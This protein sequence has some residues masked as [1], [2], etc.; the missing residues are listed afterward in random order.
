MNWTKVI[1][2]LLTVAAITAC[3]PQAKV[4]TSDFE[5][6]VEDYIRKFPYQDTHNYVLMYTQGDPASFNTWVLGSEPTLVKA[7]DD[8]IV[9][10][11]NDTFY[12]M[13]FVI[14][15]NGPVVLGSSAPS[16]GRFISF[17]LMDDRNVNYRNVIFPKGTYTLYHGE[18]PEE[19]QGEAI[20]V[21]SN[22]SVVIV[23][24]EVKDKNNPEDLAAATAV[25]KGITI[26]G[27]E[28]EETP[29]LDLLSG[30]D[31]AVEEEALL[32]MEE[33]L[34]TVPFIETVVGPGKKPGTD[35]PYLYHAAGT[36]GGWGGPDPTHSTYESLFTDDAGETLNGANG[37]Y[38]ITTEEPP[39]DAFWSITVYDT[40]R[41]GFLHPNK[42]DRYHIN[43]TGAVKNADGTVTFTFKQKCEEGDLN[44]LEVPAGPFD[45]VIRYYLPSEKIIS[46]EW[47]L[48]RPKLQGE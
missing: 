4:Q 27:P 21:P 26:D 42:D 44:C 17:Q 13:A 18:K 15:E 37:T 5:K 1:T 7:G 36:K 25:F 43:N 39:V 3:S 22:L 12:N 2:V 40:K 32:R 24:V 33:T 38:T 41:G 30:F 14:L 48:P 6:Q 16:E 31:K 9:R 29:E 46:G 19:V 47:T 10:T 11:N 35:V 34:R 20:E 8:K 28:L 45:L 23:R